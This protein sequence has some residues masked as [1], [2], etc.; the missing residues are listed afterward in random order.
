M[1]VIASPIARHCRQRGETAANAAQLAASWLQGH[2]RN[3]LLALAAV[4]AMAFAA[5]QTW[6]KY[7]ATHAHWETYTLAGKDLKI[8][9]MD[10]LGRVL[11]TNLDS[12]QFDAP[13]M[14]KLQD[15]LLASKF[16][17]GVQDRRFGDQD[18]I[19]S[20]RRNSETAWQTTNTYFRSPAAVTVIPI[21]PGLPQQLSVRVRMV[22]GNDPISDYS[23]ATVVTVN[24]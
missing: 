24:P 22:I 21:Q 7:G 6:K 3:A 11:Y 1:W 14:A 13:S 23:S 15:E 20:Y 8:H 4:A 9:L 18:F 19:V 10:S 12:A 16:E 17:N 2:R 5:A